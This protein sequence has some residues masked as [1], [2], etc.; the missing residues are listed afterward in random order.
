[1]AEME[2]VPTPPNRPTIIRAKNQ[3]DGPGPP[4]P[5]RPAP[6]VRPS[7]PPSA[8]DPTQPSAD[9]HVKQAASVS[10]LTPQV[11]QRPGVPPSQHQHGS[12]PGNMSSSSVQPSP[13]TSVKKRPEITVVSARPMNEVGFRDVKNEP[14]SKSDEPIQSALNSTE[15]NTSLSMKSTRDDGNLNK[16][17]VAARNLPSPRIADKAPSKGAPPQISIRTSDHTGTSVVDTLTDLTLNAKLEEPSAS[18]PVKD[19]PLRPTIIRPARP[20][21]ASTTPS[22]NDGSQLD[23]SQPPCP[24]PRQKRVN[25]SS[26]TT[27]LTLLSETEITST[28]SPVHVLPAGP[29]AVKLKPTVIPK[30]ESDENTGLGEQEKKP[31]GPKDAPPRPV[32]TPRKLEPNFKQE[33]PKLSDSKSVQ[34]IRDIERPLPTRPGPGH[35]LYHY[36]ATQPHGVASYE[37][38]ASQPDELSFQ[39]GDIILLTKQI[40]S[41]WMLGKNGNQEGLFPSNFIEIRVPFGQQ[42]KVPVESDS[43]SEEEYFDATAEKPDLIGQGPRCR[44]RFDYEGGEDEDLIFEEGDVI[45]LLEKIDEEWFKGEVHGKVGMFP[46]SFVEII[47]DLPGE[48]E[49]VDV[50][51][52]AEG[53]TSHPGHMTTAVFGYS[54][55]VGELTFKE[56]D[57]IKVLGF[58]KKGW[59]VGEARGKRGKFPANFIDAEFEIPPYEEEVGLDLHTANHGK[60]KTSRKKSTVQVIMEH[61]QTCQ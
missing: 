54:G 53:A 9:G 10:R 61:G 52:E 56:G 45:K 4:V 8:S 60:K 28:Q 15:Q 37:Y 33:P 35:P 13:N 7:Q 48:G 6:P 43:D 59:L 21:P 5:V 23:S 27:D 34:G 19:K 40:D 50:V 25:E 16:P 32:F 26:G 24:K 55:G 58:V 30:P 29:A 11:P 36:M 17:V 41:N 47:K 51:Y 20:N 18:M 3:T 22:R 46:A 31:T 39:V 14:L 42:Q 49:V 2:T 57:K 38:T 44:A 1:M 12:S